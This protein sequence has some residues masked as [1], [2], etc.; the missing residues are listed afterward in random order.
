MKI[1]FKIATPEKVVY[2]DEVDQATLPTK[3]GEIT[4]LP[5][6]I[7]VV[8]S[9]VAG[10]ILVKKEGQEIP[11]ATSGGFVELSENKIVILADTAERIDEIDEQKAEEAKQ[12]V[13]ELMERKDSEAKVDYTALAAK[14]EKELARLRVAKKYKNL[15]RGPQIKIEED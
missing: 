11:M 1:K 5:N 14:M 8:S 15:K 12:R 6:H 9:L 2:E 4:I 13:K 7:P 3:M 10:E